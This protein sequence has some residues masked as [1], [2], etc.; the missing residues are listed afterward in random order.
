LETSS[1]T[2]EPEPIEFSSDPVDQHVTV[3][4]SQNVAFNGSFCV[5]GEAIAV[6]IRTAQDTVT[7]FKMLCKLIK[8][9][10]YF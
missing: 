7:D 3:F 5:D 2:G 8:L 10:A 9:F 1:I 4:E 6:V